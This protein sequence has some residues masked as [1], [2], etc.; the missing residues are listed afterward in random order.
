MYSILDR[1]VELFRAKF[2]PHVSPDND[3]ADLEIDSLALVELSLQVE[4]E[5]HVRLNERVLDVS[6]L[7]ELA[8]LIE[9]LEHEQLARVGRDEH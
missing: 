1:L 8:E 3:F 2:G 7:H 9:E 6:S 5:F 4:Q